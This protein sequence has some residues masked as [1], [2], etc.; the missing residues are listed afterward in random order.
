MNW[1]NGEVIGE[2]EA[3]SG[4]QANPNIQVNDVEREIIKVRSALVVI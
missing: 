4:G 2:N 3:K 1:K